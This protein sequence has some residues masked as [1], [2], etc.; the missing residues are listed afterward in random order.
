MKVKY[1]KEDTFITGWCNIKFLVYLI[2]ISVGWG[3]GERMINGCEGTVNRSKKFWCAVSQQ[4]DCR[5]QVPT[6]YL[7]RLEE[8]IGCFHHKEMIHWVQW[9]AAIVPATQLP[10]V[11]GQP[12]Q[13]SDTPSQKLM[14]K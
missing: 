5:Y 1:R 9:D 3:H 8:K 7:R 10:G 2:K 11:Q 13:Y 14:N 12:R 4:G 6:V